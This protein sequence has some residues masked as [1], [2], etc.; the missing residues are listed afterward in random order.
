MCLSVLCNKA[1]KL[2]KLNLCFDMLDENADGFITQEET[3][4]MLSNALLDAKGTT[5]HLYRL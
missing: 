1:S 2:E 5:V 3:N 4:C